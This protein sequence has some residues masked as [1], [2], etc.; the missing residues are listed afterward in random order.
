[1][2]N[3]QGPPQMYNQGP[4]Q[5]MYN[6][7]QGP[8]QHNND[9]YKTSMC[10]NFLQS[11]ECTYGEKCRFAH[12]DQELRSGGGGGGNGGGNGGNRPTGVCR[13]FMENGDCKFGANCK[14]SHDCM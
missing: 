13:F 12:G 1:M 4:P 14:F 5:Q 8:P 3:N 11:G 10:R 9:K 2:Y 7:N 6:Y